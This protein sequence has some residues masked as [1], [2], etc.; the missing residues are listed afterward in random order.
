MLNYTC[1]S[2]TNDKVPLF[3]IKN[4][5]ISLVFLFDSGKTVCLLVGQF[6]Q[7]NVQFAPRK[8]AGTTC[9]NTRVKPQ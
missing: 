9:K 6:I 2:D 7:P 4:T 8:N 5:L 3:Q 1:L